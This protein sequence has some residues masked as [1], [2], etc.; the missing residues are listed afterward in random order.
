L[1]WMTNLPELFKV[2]ELVHPKLNY[3]ISHCQCQLILKIAGL[4]LSWLSWF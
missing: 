4:M 2:L 1:K 3:C